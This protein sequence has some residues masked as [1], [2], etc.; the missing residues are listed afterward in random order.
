MYAEQICVSEANGLF[1][2]LFVFCKNA[3]LSTD[4]RLVQLLGELECIKCDLLL[5]QK[6]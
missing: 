6:L 1:K 4:E 5:S 2:G 3:R